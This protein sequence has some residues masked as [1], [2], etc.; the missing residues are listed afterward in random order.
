MSTNRI[1]MMLPLSGTQP[2]VA[3]LTEECERSMEEIIR[4]QASET[5]LADENIRLNDQIDRL[6]SENESLAAELRSE[7]S[8]CGAAWRCAIFA[9]YAMTLETLAVAGWLAYRWFCL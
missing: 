4:L 6:Q 1:R 3:S 5:I 9:A 2:L 7:K 8:E